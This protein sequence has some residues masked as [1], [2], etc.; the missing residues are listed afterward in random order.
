MIGA[1]VE[2]AIQGIMIIATEQRS[3]CAGADKARHIRDSLY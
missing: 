1:K 2:G 3:S